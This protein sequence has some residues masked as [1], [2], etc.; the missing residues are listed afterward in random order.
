MP[1]H[2]RHAYP[3]MLDVSD[4][5]VVIVGGGGVAA[6]KARGILDAGGRR[7]RVVAPDF[8]PELPAGVE[9]V[10]ERYHPECLEGA[11]LVFA[12]T[13]VPEVNDA[14][15]RDARARGVLVCRADGNDA[16][17]GDFA[18]PAHLH[19]GEVT[20]AVSAGSAA[21]A[22]RVRDAL[23]AHFDPVWSRMA[24]AMLALRPAIRDRADIA[25]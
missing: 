25:P 10:R 4:R 9:R 18:T 20:L 11:G 23:A 14:V 3:L 12:A 13:D 6:R 15:V 5:L 24:E 17:P 22:V 16:E 8:A 1:R 21:L 2:V 7:V 19:R